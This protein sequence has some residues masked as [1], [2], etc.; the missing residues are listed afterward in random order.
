V[1]IANVNLPGFPENFGK[2]KKKEEQKPLPEK[3]KLPKKQSVAKFNP[4]CQSCID[5]GE[6]CGYCFD[7]PSQKD[8]KKVVEKQLQDAG[9]AEDFIIVVADAYTI[10]VDLDTED[11]LRH[12]DKHI[13]ILEPQLAIENVIYTRSKSDRWHVTIKSKQSWNDLSRVAIQ[14]CLGSDR[15]RETLNI[16]NVLQGKENAILF[17][18]RKDMWQQIMKTTGGGTLT[19]KP[20]DVVEE[21]KDEETADSLPAQEVALR[22]L[23]YM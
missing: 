3:T 9:M 8:Q 17:I 14:A 22:H 12:F 10:Q 1:P 16:K 6:A 2:W 20:V 15:M 13:K 18:E 5:N 19:I 7:D 11:D 21:F 4:E 23:S